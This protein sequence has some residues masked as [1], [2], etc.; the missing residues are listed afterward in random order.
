MCT[1][2]R[3]FVFPPFSSRFQLAIIVKV[4]LVQSISYLFFLFLSSKKEKNEAESSEREAKRRLNNKI[5]AQARQLN[6]SCVK[7]PLSFSFYT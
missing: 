4:F 7:T 6:G 5:K 3:T 2:H 1:L